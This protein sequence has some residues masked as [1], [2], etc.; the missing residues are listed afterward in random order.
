MLV[1][2]EMLTELYV[3][4]YANLFEELFVVK[5]PYVFPNVLMNA[6]VELLQEL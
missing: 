4:A 3:T 5:I 2:I 1:E 6:D